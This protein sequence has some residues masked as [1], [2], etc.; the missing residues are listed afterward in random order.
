[1]E[2]E[3]SITKKGKE[4]TYKELKVSDYLVEFLKDYD[5]LKRYNKN[6]SNYRKNRYEGVQQFFMLEYGDNFK[7]M[8]ELEAVRFLVGNTNKAIKLIEKDPKNFHKAKY[9][10]GFLE[11]N[12]KI[13]KSQTEYNIVIEAIDNIPEFN[14]EQFDLMEKYSLKVREELAKTKTD[15]SKNR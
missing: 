13:N 6:L 10:L 15:Q 8:D 12:L 5:L 2:T 7:H 4:K 9:W 3:F 14:E 11:D 1:M